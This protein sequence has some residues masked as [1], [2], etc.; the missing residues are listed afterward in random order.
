MKLLCVCLGNICRSPMAA[1]VL[2]HQAAQHPHTRSWIIDSA[3]T[4]AW[5]IGKP[6]DRRTIA[7]LRREGVPSD[8]RARQVQ[9]ADFHVFDRILAMDRQNLA[10]LQ[11]RQ[12][13][14]ATAILE[15]FGDYDP[16]GIAE[17]PDPYYG[18][19]A[20]FDTV[21]AQVLRCTQAFIGRHGR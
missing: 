11:A 14:D 21:Y 1:A 5:H 6:A 9:P 20:G 4:G 18:E 7:V 19:D 2:R 15:L 10:D 16:H 13:R 8:H 3:G 12:P 17:V